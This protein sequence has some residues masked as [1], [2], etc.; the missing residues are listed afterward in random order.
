MT[1]NENLEVQPFARIAFI[2]E[3]LFLL[4]GTPSANFPAS[5]QRLT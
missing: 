4:A 3:L 5:A 1:A 2:E